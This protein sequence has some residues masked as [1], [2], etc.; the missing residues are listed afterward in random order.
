[1]FDK[2]SSEDREY[3]DVEVGRFKDDVDAGHCLMENINFR[4]YRLE[5]GYFVVYETRWLDR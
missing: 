3:E 1:M 5:D 2:H 4:F